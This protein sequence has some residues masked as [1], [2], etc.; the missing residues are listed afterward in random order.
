MEFAVEATP[1]WVNAIREK[2]GKANTKYA[3]VGY[4]FGAPF[5][6]NE[7]AGSTVSAGA[8]GHPAF[9]EEHHFTSLKS[10][11]CGNPMLPISSDS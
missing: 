4:C 6:C 9:L 11:F 3:C 1:T 5:V 7:L 10:T 8:F 2:Y